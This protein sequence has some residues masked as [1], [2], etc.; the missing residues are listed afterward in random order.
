MALTLAF[1]MVSFACSPAWAASK[2]LSLGSASQAQYQPAAPS[3]RAGGPN[4][5]SESLPFT[6][7]WLLPLLAGGIVL[8]A[9]GGILRSRVN[10]R[11]Q[12]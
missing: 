4:N 6:G 8:T 10:E 1:T 5:V 11:R 3:L 9:V 2:S 12:R 7:A